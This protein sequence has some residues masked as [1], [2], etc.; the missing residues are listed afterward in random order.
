M[1]LAMY[2]GAYEYYSNVDDWFLADN[3]YRWLEGAGALLDIDAAWADLNGS[4]LDYQVINIYGFPVPLVRTLPNDGFL[5]QYAV[6]F[7]HAVR[8]EQ[9][10]G[11]IAHTF[12][13]RDDRVRDRVQHILGED[14]FLPIRQ[15]GSVAYMSISPGSMTVPRT[16]TAQ[17]TATALDIDGVPLT[18]K[19]IAWSSDNP[20]I[21][22]VSASGLVSGVGLGTTVIRAASEGY[23]AAVTIVVVNAPIVSISGPSRVRSGATCQYSADVS[24]GTPPYT[25]TWF[26]GAMPAGNSQLMTYHNGSSSFTITLTVRDAAS[27]SGNASRTITISPTA[28]ICAF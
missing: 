25:Y 5:P 13:V 18:G 7:P 6:Q 11:D 3:A 15:P 12:Q 17:L 21:A 10:G 23:G 20:S 8:N 26:V 2:L 22:S 19:P 27:L 28:P 9:V 14:F 24:L 16:S 4:L 1:A